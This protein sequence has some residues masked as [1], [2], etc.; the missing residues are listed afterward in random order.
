V[1]GLFVIVLRTLQW[2]ELFGNPWFL[3]A[4]VLILLIFGLS[5]FGF[6]TVGL[7]TAV[8]RFTPRH[9]T[10]LGNFLFGIL[11]A[12]L[13]TPCTF[14]LFLGLLIWAVAQPAAIGLLLLITVGVGMA[15]PYVI[16]SAVPEVARR[17]PRTG[18]WAELVKQ[19]MGFLLIGSAVYFAKRFLRG[20]FGEDAFWWLLFAV[21]AIAGIY[22]LVRSIQFSRRLIPRMVAA[23]VALLL[24]APALAFTIRQTNPPIDWQPYT[25]ES[26]AAAREAGKTVML[27]FTA[28]WCGNCI[29][30]ETS[31]FHDPRTVEA[32]KAYKVV[33]I[34]VDLSDQHAPGWQVLRQ[35]SPVGAIPLSAI[36][37]PHASEPIQL[38]GLYSP[39]DLIAALRATKGDDAPASQPTTSPVD[40][41]R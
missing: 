10:Y 15:F 1:L 29:G 27:E 6:F 31:T 23:A 2:G 38:A 25:P 18:P 14:G 24:V 28:D 8:Y 19:M 39:A 21:V 32:I 36:Y 33:P 16:L 34:R 22:L 13:S 5:Q 35:I 40:N 11:T 41:V 37:A 26:F 12:I 4:I 7:P 17:F 3:A 9:D 20:W 30:L